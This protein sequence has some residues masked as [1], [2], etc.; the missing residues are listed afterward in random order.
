M[1]TSGRNAHLLHS[2][3]KRL[4]AQLNTAWQVLHAIGYELMH[5]AGSGMHCHQML[6]IDQSRGA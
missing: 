6:S 2:R 5:R 1:L 3:R 4:Q